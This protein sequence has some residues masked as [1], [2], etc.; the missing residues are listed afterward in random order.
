MSLTLIETRIKFPSH[1]YTMP[2]LETGTC[3]HAASRHHSRLVQTIRMDAWNQPQSPR[4]NIHS[5]FLL[6]NS[7]TCTKKMHCPVQNPFLTFL[8]GWEKSFN[9]LS[10]QM[11]YR[12][13]SS[14]FTLARNEG[15]VM[16]TNV[17]WVKTCTLHQRV[18]KKEMC[19]QS[20]LFLSI[21]EFGG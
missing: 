3:N 20:H 11:G 16:V 10:E 17:I 6:P 2:T 18:Q 15:L 12:F 13:S 5:G 19:G 21:L 14:I 1:T 9:A 4:P 7:R 8:P